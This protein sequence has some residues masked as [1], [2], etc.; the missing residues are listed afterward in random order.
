MRFRGF[1]LIEM[2]VTNSVVLLM[3]IAF[4]W[5]L[6][7]GKSTYQ[8]STAR[9]AARQTLDTT[10]A[11][12]TEE[13]RNSRPASLAR[14]T[15]PLCVSFASAYDATGVFRTTDAGDPQWQKQVILWWDQ[16]RE[17]LYRKELP[18]LDATPLNQSQLSAATATPGQVV[19]RGVRGFALNAIPGGTFELVLST[20]SAN[21]QGGAIEFT[22]TSTFLMRN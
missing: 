14:L 4:S 3:I 10:L 5:M 20:H 1:T 7:A 17:Q 16:P 15:V 19:L 13:F 21:Q 11:K 8:T 22:V 12:L 6:L 2:L 9:S 18:G